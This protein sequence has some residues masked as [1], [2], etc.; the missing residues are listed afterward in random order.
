MNRFKSQDIRCCLSAKRLRKKR[1]HYVSSWLRR[2]YTTFSQKPNPFVGFG[3]ANDEGFTLP[4]LDAYERLT[5]T[6]K[7]LATQKANQLVEES[8]GKMDEGL[9]M[10]IVL[11]EWNTRE[12][13][14]KSTHKLI[15][16][17]ILILGFGSIAL[18]A[19]VTGLLSKAHA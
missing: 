17:R 4:F 19:L 2:Q 13:E 16:V 15:N 8:K 14:S 7:E 10:Q 3:E 5:E 6:E 12:P 11:T 9:A 18:Y 1:Q